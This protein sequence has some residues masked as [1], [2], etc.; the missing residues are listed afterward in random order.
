M[1]KAKAVTN[2]IRVAGF[3]KDKE[4][5]PWMGQIIRDLLFILP[6]QYGRYCKQRTQI[7]TL[8]DNYEQTRLSQAANGS[9]PPVVGTY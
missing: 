1:D 8:I 5:G 4:V 9:G 2:I 3:Y 6:S 7:L